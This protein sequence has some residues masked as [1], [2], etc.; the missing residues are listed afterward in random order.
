MFYNHWNAY[1]SQSSLTYTKKQ[2]FHIILEG[3][4]CFIISILS[5]I[6]QKW[7]LIFNTAY[8]LLI[9]SNTKKPKQRA[10]IWT[11]LVTLL[12]WGFP[13]I[14]SSHIFIM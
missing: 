12:Y 3:H 11:K 5:F 8:F 4:L 6:I 14:S 1:K 7:K 2:T 9:W 13:Q 10:K